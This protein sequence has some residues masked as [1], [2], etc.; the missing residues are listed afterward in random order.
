MNLIKRNNFLLRIEP[1]SY[2][3]TTFELLPYARFDWHAVRNLEISI[4]WGFWELEFDIYWGKE[5]DDWVEH[6]GSIIRKLDLS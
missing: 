6:E 5:G 1:F 3:P 2:W 4:G